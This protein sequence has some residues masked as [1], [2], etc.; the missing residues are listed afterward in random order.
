M[1]AAVLEDV[2]KLVYREDYPKPVI[3]ADDALIR[4]RYCGI[5]GS[6]ITNYRQGLYKLPLVPGHEL[7]GEVEALGENVEGFSIGDRVLGINVKLDVTREMRGLGVFQDGGFAEYVRVPRDFLFHAPEGLSFQHSAMVESYAL[8]MR[9]M[10]VSHIEDDQNIVILG[11]GNVGLTL[12]GGLIVKKQPH[13]IVLIEP[14]EFLRAKGKEVGASETFGLSKTKIRKYFKENGAPGYIYDC[15]GTD[16][17]FKLAMDL[18]KP[19]GNI[20]LEGLYRG[21]VPIPLMMMN[22]KEICI[23]GVMGHDRED[24]LGAI[25]LFD[26]KQVDPS[27]IISEVVPLKDIQKTFERYLEPGER[28]FVKIL[29][30][31]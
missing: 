20:I 29:V 17:S 23:K 14:Q 2:G 7:A 8:G 10:K 11:G 26:R 28:Q 4:V 13:Y 19:G 1:R 21:T 30:E 27:P 5:C 16:K 6:D 18:I 22:S 12:M 3:G 9:A 24:I 25:E 15:A 31:I